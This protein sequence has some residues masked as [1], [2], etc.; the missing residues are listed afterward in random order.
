MFNQNVS[1]L[2]YPDYNQRI[3][4][5]YGA[6]VKYEDGEEQKYRPQ[7]CT[8]HFAHCFLNIFEINNDLFLFAHRK[9]MVSTD[10]MM[11]IMTTEDTNLISF[12]K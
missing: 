11:M 8:N 5:S 7:V 12:S 10:I 2:D 3:Y 4:N 9:I 1:V 6:E